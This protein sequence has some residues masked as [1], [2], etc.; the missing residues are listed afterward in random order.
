R[1]LE[2]PQHRLHGGSLDGRQITLQIDD[3]IDRSVRVDPAQRLQH[4]VRAG[5][6]LGAR[7]DRLKAPRLDHL[8]DFAAV[9]RNDDA[10]SP[11]LPGPLGDMDDHGRALDIR[12]RLARNA[13]RGKARGDQYDG[14]HGGKRRFRTGWLKVA[15]GLTWK[16]PYMCCNAR[17]KD[18]V[19][20]RF[21]PASAE[22]GSAGM[23]GWCMR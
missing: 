3:S 15:K 22:G 4:T 12:E 18:L 17:A 23:A 16:A 14:R 1:P 11:A 13:R 20:A 7:H 9:G 8:S 2:R 10:P 19:S 6:V 21:L 5:F